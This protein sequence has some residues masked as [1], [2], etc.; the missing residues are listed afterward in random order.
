VIVGVGI[1]VVEVAR[2]RR[3]LAGRVRG[4]RF[5]ARVFTEGERSYCDAR[6]DRAVHYAAR[7][8]AKEAALKALGVPEGIRLTDV[9]VERGAGAPALRFHREAKRAA[10][11]LAVARAHL[12]ITHDAGIAAATV[13][14]ERGGR[15]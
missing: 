12:A 14:L 1:D 6:P 7:F 11:A 2:I 3:L 8:A 5:A 9:E 10:A 13:V 15:R 4:A